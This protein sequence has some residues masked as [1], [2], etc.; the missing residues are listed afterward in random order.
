[1]T[2]PTPNELFSLPLPIR[3]ALPFENPDSLPLISS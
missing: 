3:V 1:M 2:F